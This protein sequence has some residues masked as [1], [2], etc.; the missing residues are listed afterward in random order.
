MDERTDDLTDRFVKALDRLDVPRRATPAFTHAPRRSWFPAAA[1]AAAVLLVALVLVPALAGRNANVAGPDSGIAA[2]PSPS[3]SPTAT[4]EPTKPPWVNTTQPQL[5]LVTSVRWAIDRL[6]TG[7][8]LI[9][10]Y[11][12]HASSFRIVDE[13]GATV[14]QIPIAGSGIFGD[15]SCVVSARQPQEGTTWRRIDEAALDLFVQ[16]YRS[17]RVIADGIPTG[18]VTLELVDSGCRGRS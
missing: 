7:P 17:Y 9:L 2:S 16:R 13:N 18:Q 3:P 1:V 12:G 14:L 10:L 11:E 4:V 6:P 15:E 8:M 5:S